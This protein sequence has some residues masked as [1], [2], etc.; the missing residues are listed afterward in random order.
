[1]FEDI[2]DRFHPPLE[3]VLYVSWIRTLESELGHPK[4]EDVGESGIKVM[5]EVY[6]HSKY[7][8]RDKE[9]FSVRG[10]TPV[11]Q[12]HNFSQRGTA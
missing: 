7:S 4:Q 1:V 9:L 2:F 10:G 3:F 12:K 8:I 11:Q 6:V 5:R